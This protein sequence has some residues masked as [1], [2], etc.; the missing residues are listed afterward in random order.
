MDSMPTKSVDT[1]VTSPPYNLL[2]SSGGG[3]KGKGGGAWVGSALIAGQG[4][5]RNNDN[6]PHEE[7]VEWQRK[8]LTSMMRLLKDDG[9]IFYNHKWRVQSG[10]W[11]DR[12]DIVAGFPVRQIIIW[13]RSGGMNHNPGYFLPTYEVIYL[14]T[15]PDFKLSQKSGGVGDVWYIPQEQGNPHPASFPIALAKR[16]IMSTQGDV[17]MDPF[18]GSGNTAIAADALGREW[19]GVDIS[20]AYCNM[21]RERL[22][23]WN[24]IF[25]DSGVL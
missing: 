2:N 3:M 20:P 24:C 23:K 13:H 12:S 11:Q 4:Y 7:Y 1:I 22:K 18:L 15:K 5:D 21:A 16:C 25:E 9:A 6:M 14:I 10:L 19:I 17:V 8:C